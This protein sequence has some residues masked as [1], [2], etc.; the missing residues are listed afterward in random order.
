MKFSIVIP[1]YNS[2]NTIA[3]TIESVLNQTYKDLELVIVNDGSTDKSLDVIDKYLNDNRV[4]VYSKENGGLSSA[5][6]YGVKKTT[7]D[8]IG[9]IDA[10]DIANIDW[11]ETIINKIEDYDTI[12]FGYKTISNNKVINDYKVKEYS[13][14]NEE[15]M[16]DLLNKYYFE[17]NA[18]SAFKYISVHRWATISKRELVLQIIDK[19]E[20]LNF[21]L[22]EDYVYVSL[23][24]SKSSTVKAIDYL[25][26]DYIQNRKSHSH[27]NQKSYEELLELR[28]KL[29]DYL[30]NF[31]IENNLNE[32]IFK[33]MEFDVSKFYASRIM[34]THSYRVSKSFFKLLK[35]DK[36]YCE[37]KKYVN[38]SDENFKRR[39]YFFFL[40]H[41]MFFPIF[42]TFKIFN[43]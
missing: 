21:C 4:K 11:L 8:Y 6:A 3:K 33:T 12:A 39:V 2:E 35:K 34:K 36:I 9:F 23:I 24:L 25:A 27:T 22:Y 18:F 32:D 10:D 30:H 26:I 29:R 37:E 14:D 41:N 31:C 17:K 19:Y 42:I 5:I 1:C 43:F 7:G 15:K 20:K 28:K 16:K 13:Y 38:L 40:K